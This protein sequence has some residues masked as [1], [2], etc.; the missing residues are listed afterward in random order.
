MFYLFSSQPI[1]TMSAQQNQL[2]TVTEE[3]FVRFKQGFVTS[4]EVKTN[5]RL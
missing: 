5:V 1:F 2:H 4:D 3:Q